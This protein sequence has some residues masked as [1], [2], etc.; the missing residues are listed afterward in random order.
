VPELMELARRWPFMPKEDVASRTQA[1]VDGVV[2]RCQTSGVTSTVALSCE[3]L[4]NWRINDTD[5][6]KTG[7][8]VSPRNLPWLNKDRKGKWPLAMF[9]ANHLVPT[10]SSY[11]RIRVALGLRRQADW[12]ASQYAQ[13]SSRVYAPSQFD[14]ERQLDELIDRKDPYIFWDR[15]VDDL[16]SAVGVPNLHIFLFEDL[17]FPETWTKLACFLGLNAEDDRISVAQSVKINRRSN[18][19]RSWNL[20]RSRREVISQS[21]DISWPE[22]RLPSFR[23]GVL[24]AA[25]ML[26]RVTGRRLTDLQ[27]SPAVGTIHLRE[28]LNEML[29]SYCAD[30]NKRLSHIIGRDLRELG[31]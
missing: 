13:M 22:Q 17:V 11:G 26:D 1:W 10:W 4:L 9:L 3:Q 18:A 2:A 30:S 12:L 25:R 29:R 7:L 21:V 19:E 23:S 15:L 24:S 6:L 8:A 14:F 5:F 27:L 16:S 31:Y 28:E 20:R